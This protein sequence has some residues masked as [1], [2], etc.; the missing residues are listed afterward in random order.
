MPDPSERSRPGPG[1]WLLRGVGVAALLALLVLI[2]VGGGRPLAAGVAAPR[3]VGTTIQGQPF[4]LASWKGHTVVVNVWATWC[5]PC[6]QELPEFEALSQ[7][8]EPRGVRFVGLAA[9]SPPADIP[10]M[11]E[12][13]GVTF[14]VLPINGLVQ[15]AWNVSAF[16]STFI[17]APDGHVAWSVRGAVHG[18]DLD[19]ALRD[20]VPA[21]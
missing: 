1:R 2:M 17:V 13:T 11:V 7:T 15:R 8:W 6:L 5:G 10:R 3:T 20:V 9:D 14:P 12:R 21:G 16:P 18:H 4:D 19:A